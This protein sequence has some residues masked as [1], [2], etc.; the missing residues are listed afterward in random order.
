MLKKTIRTVTALAVIFSLSTSAFALESNPTVSN[1]IQ[2]TSSSNSNNSVSQFFVSYIDKVFN[3]I[4][5]LIVKDSNDVDITKQFIQT[6]KDLY[7]NRDYITIQDI[8]KDQ[9]LSVSYGVTTPIKSES[10][11]FSANAISSQRVSREFYHIGAD[12]ET[13]SY[14]KEWTVTVSGSISYNTSTYNIT[15][16]SGVSVSLTTADF[17]F[18]FAP[19]LEGT[20]GNGTFSGQTATLYGSYTL[21]A[22]YTLQPLPLTKTLNYGYHTDSF[23]AGPTRY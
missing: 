4:D 23:D 2:E 6:T 12:L 20:S 5:G 8:I 11:N 1:N 17:G 22:N 21:K 10:N 3:N 7:R 16:V 19:Y 18:N 13:R 14:N 15:G 9:N